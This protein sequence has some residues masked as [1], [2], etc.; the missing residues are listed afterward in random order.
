MEDEYASITRREAVK[1][2]PNSE[3]HISW[4][5]PYQ[6]PAVV[7]KEVGNII[8][9]QEIIPQKKVTVA[10]SIVSITEAVVVSTQLGGQ[11][12]TSSGEDVV[13]NGK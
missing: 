5:A 1:V 3:V 12:L 8:V 11:I 2:G 4:Y 7:Q 6:K 9:G 10:D 13:G